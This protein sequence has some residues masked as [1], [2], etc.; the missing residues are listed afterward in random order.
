MTYSALQRDLFFDTLALIEDWYADPFKAQALDTKTPSAKKPGASVLQS[1]EYPD[2][3]KWRNRWR[4][5]EGDPDKERRAATDIRR[6]YENLW[7]SPS[8]KHTHVVNTLEWEQAI[9]RSKLELQQVMRL[10]DVPRSTVYRFRELHGGKVVKAPRQAAR[11]KQAKN[12]RNQGKSFSWIG[13]Q[14]GVSKKTAH[15]WVTDPPKGER[16]RNLPV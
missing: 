14:F 9:G 2:S 4:Y 1:G 12:Y 15:K 13:E 11:V 8:Q 6:E 16:E 10:Y 7:M 3:V 5:A